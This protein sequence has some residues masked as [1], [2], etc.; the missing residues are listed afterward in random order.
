MLGRFLGR[1]ASAT[2]KVIG[3]I[4]PVIRRI[5]SF[6][7]THH[8]PIAM[9]ASGLAAQ[10]SNP[11]VHKLGAAAALGSAFLTQKG[12]GKNYLQPPAS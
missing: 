12:I 9:L 6:A 5:G 1:V 8:Q 11:T 3:N 2:S 4:A 7:V 10:S